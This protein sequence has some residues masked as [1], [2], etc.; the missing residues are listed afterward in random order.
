MRYDYFYKVTLHPQ[1]IISTP[2]LN[3]IVNLPDKIFRGKRHLNF[4]SFTTK[5]RLS[6]PVAIYYH[7]DNIEYK[8]FLLEN[9]TL[10]GGKY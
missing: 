6:F 8:I 9:S 1:H 3:Q 10:I 4:A 7:I 5:E 2:C